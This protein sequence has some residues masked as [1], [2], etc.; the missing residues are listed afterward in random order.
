MALKNLQYDAVTNI[1]SILV[2]KDLFESTE[3][4]RENIIERIEKCIQ[5][6]K[7]E[8]SKAQSLQADCVPEAR[9]MII[10]SQKKLKG[11]ESLIVLANLI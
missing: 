5:L 3:N 4:L 7:S 9:G 10:R 11:L 6:T 2:E 8:F 1:L